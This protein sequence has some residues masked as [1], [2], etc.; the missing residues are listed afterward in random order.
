MQSIFNF[1]FVALDVTRLM[2]SVSAA[3][4]AVL[5]LVVM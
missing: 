3:H 5:L 2:S 4:T 1:S